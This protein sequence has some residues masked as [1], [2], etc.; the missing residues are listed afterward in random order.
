MNTK[1]INCRIKYNLFYIFGYNLI[2]E[3]QF[4]HNYFPIVSTEKFIQ[5][6]GFMTKRSVSLELS[7]I[8]RPYGIPVNG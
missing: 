7:T 5:E 4:I 3:N 6:I 2:F 1:Y 8:R